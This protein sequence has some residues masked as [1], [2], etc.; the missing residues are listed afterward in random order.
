MINVLINGARGKM[1]SEAVKAV[2][3]DP[4]LDLVGKAG[5]EDTLAQMIAVTHPDVVVDLTH[6]ST[7][8]ENCETIL[9][10]SAH[11][12]IGT[13]GLSENDLSALDRLA[14]VQG[15]GIFI[16]PNFAI[17]AVLMMQFAAEAAAHLPRVEILE[18]HHDKKVDAPSGTAIKTAEVIAQAN[19]D[20]NK[21]QRK[22]N[23]LI[24]IHSIRLP[25]I[26]ANQEVILGGLGQT[27]TIRHD[28]ISREAFMPGLLLCIKKIGET[29][30]LT[31][32]LEKVLA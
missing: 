17:G 5:R 31:Y 13:T 2:T 29:E 26:V 24:P 1:G 19:P 16:I 21:M 12:V 28:T 20:V 10:A 6:P 8:R 32:G 18:Y 15:K 22:D 30:G 27:L 11:A 23:D 9:N 3:Q 4:E 25:G 7:I 14:K